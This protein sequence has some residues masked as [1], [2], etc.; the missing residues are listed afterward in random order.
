MDALLQHATE[1]ADQ[2]STPLFAPIQGRVAYVVS[3]GQSY[4]SN[5]YAI[6]TQGIAQALNAHGLETLCFVRPGRPWELG[7]R[8]DRIAPEVVVKGVRYIHSRWPQAQVPDDELEH[9]KASVSRYLEL[10]RVY[11][12][13]A[14]LAASNYIVGLPAW[15]AAKRLGLPFYNEVRGFWELSRDAREPG[16]ANT[17]AFKLEAERDTFVAKQARRLFTLNQPMQHELA[18]RGVEP[19]RIEI[20]PNGVTEQPEPKPADPVLKARLGI[21]E[22]DTVLGYVGSFNAYEGLNTLVEACA[23]LVKQGERIKLLL[24]GDDQPITEATGKLHLENHPWLIQAGRVPHEK[25]EDYYALIDT[26]VI[27]RKKLPVCDLVPPMKAAEALAYGKRLLVSDVVPLAEYANKYEGVVS[28]EAGSAESLARALQRSMKLPVSKPSTEL[29]FSKHTEQM[30]RALKGEKNA[31]VQKAAVDAQAE[32]AAAELQTT[33]AKRAALAQPQSR[34]GTLSRP[35]TVELPQKDPLWHRVPVKAGQS[36]IIE[37]ASE[38]HNV[39]GAQNRKAVLLINAF[40]ADGKAVD[41]PCGK[42]AKSGHLKAYFKYLPCTQNQIQELHS[43]TVP[44][45]VSEIH[46]GVCGFNKA[47]DEQVML[48]E[49]SMK[50]RPDKS[51]PTQFVPPSAQAAEISILGW[52]EQPPNGKPYVIGIMDEFTTGC[53]EQDVNLIQPRPDNWYALAE[54]YRPEFFFIE[55]AWKG[56]Y[57][58]WQY[59]VADYAN[60]PG[61]EVAHICQYAR[62]KGIPTLFWNKED[63]VHHQK[64]MCSAKLV[65]H[66]FTTDA[67]MKDSYQAKTGNPNVN[68]LPFAAQPALHKPAPL[69]GRKPRACFAGSWYGNR[70]AERGEAMRWLLQAANRQGLDIYDRNHGTGIFPFPEEYQAGI[71][72]SLPYKALCDEYSRY[73]V[74]LNVNSVTDS[75]TMFSRRVFELMACGT[76]VVSTYAKGIE[77]L[78]E[79]DAVW[80]VN[81]QEEANEA[82]HTLMHDDAEWRRRSLAGIREVFAKHTYAHRLNDIFDRLGIETRLPTDPAIGLVAEAHNQAELQALDRFAR[83]QSYRGFQLGIACAPGVAQLAGS[84]SE[85]ITLLQRGEKAPWLS[86]QQTVTPM[87]GW[88]SPQ[89]HYGE[90]YLRDLV[91]ASLYQPEACGWAKAL[92][93]DRF[94]YGKEAS[95]GGGLWRTEEFLKQPIKAHPEARITRADLYLADSDQFQLA[96]AA[97]QVVGG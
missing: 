81:S 16:Y 80:L 45:G 59:R 73:R 13:S 94:A 33:A 29:L 65:D 4:A 93:H 92:D 17:P 70:H 34:L 26:I 15:I 62:E 38:Y 97:Q 43:F 9:L 20:V 50:P 46:V 31:P 69:A 57:G 89:H 14:V 90:Q 7:A 8:R 53:F 86:E 72:G 27:P 32:P 37:A 87:A 67:N 47:D 74:F 66:I 56:N 75:P 88:L 79:S 96:G 44:E 77:N 85:H 19:S 42:M 91:N 12:P 52:P 30:V 78:F 1:L 64:F 55:S 36:L 21:A 71:K 23:E 54:K 61:Q 18:G 83:Q 76:P 22:A 95:L 6:R 48:R 11:R 24:V 60:K 63:P 84:L 58:S 5:G 25:V 3:H 40:D 10:F 2:P 49:L 82:L 41:K 28:F 39:K 51:Q 68:A 35:E